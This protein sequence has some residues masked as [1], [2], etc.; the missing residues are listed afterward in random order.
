M[1]STLGSELGEGPALGDVV[2]VGSR[3]GWVLGCTL[4]VGVPL[5]ELDGSKSVS[6]KELGSSLGCVTEGSAVG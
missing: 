3:L 5:G 6:G 1:G 4:V 2:V